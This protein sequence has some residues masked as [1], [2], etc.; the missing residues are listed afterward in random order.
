MEA[1]AQSEFQK[2]NHETAHNVFLLPYL[3]LA[4]RAG[5]GITLKSV[6]VICDF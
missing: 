2:Y 4:K 1:Q 6:P 5:I 3:S